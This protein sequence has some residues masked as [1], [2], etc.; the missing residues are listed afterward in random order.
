MRDKREFEFRSPLANVRRRSTL[1][2][3]RARPRP[4]PAAGRRASRASPFCWRL[5]W[6]RATSAL[7]TLTPLSTNTNDNDTRA[8]SPRELPIASHGRTGRGGEGRGGGRGE[9]G[10]CL[11]HQSSAAP[12]VHGH[13]NC[14]IILP[15]VVP[16]V[17]SS[18]APAACSSGKIC[19]ISN[20][21]APLAAQPKTS[22]QREGHC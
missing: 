6:P 10:Q 21:S 14:S 17:S 7:D 4:R 5:G 12:A 15:V 8:S 13:H 11:F 22:C 3:P 19:S 18:C 9:S 1:P 20:L 2:A 16:L